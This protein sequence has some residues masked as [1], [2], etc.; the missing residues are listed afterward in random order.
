MNQKTLFLAASLIALL[1]IGGA[2]WMMQKRQMAL[3]QRVAT[4]PVVETAVQ[5][6]AENPTDTS[7]W[8]TYR[9]EEYGFEVK[10]PK[11]WNEPRPF[12]LI[13]GNMRTYISD[14][15]RFE[16]CCKGVRIE[17]KQDLPRNVYANKLSNLLDGDLLGDTKRSI[18]GIEVREILYD[19]HYGENERVS[20]IPASANTVEL[21]RARNDSRAEQIVSTFRFINE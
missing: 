11:S 4:D 9:N 5:T 15:D 18:G 19:T 17:I 21:G 16:G 20:F 7:D 2:F 13:G 6:E 3:N 1:A 12:E 14:V 8:K 10:Y